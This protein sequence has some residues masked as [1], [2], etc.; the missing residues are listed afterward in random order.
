MFHPEYINPK[1]LINNEDILQLFKIIEKHGGV[2]RFVG[3]AVRDAIAG[4]KRSDI[5]LV[6]DLS[7]SEFSDICVE[8]GLRCVPIGI[9]FFTLDV[10][11]NNSFFKVTCLSTEDDISQEEWK[12][13]AAKRDLTINAVYADD[14]G[15][16]FDYYDGIDDLEKGV[17]K[18]I[19]RP[20]NAIKNDPIRIMRFFR[21]CAMF[22]KKI[23]RKSLKCCIENKHLLHTVSQEKIK[24]ELFKILLAPYAFRAMELVFKYGVLDFLIAPPF[25]VENLEKLD[26]LVQKLDI[27]KGIIRRLF[28]LF[29][30]SP[31][32]AERLAKIFNLNKEQKE[33]FFKLCTAKINAKSFKDSVS[34][35]K[36]IYAYGKNIC[37]DLF[38][39]YSIDNKNIEEIKQTLSVIEKTPV[40]VFP[41]KG[42]D[43]IEIGADK[44]FLSLYMDVL[45]KEWFENGCTYSKE[46]LLEQFKLIFKY[47]V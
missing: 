36:N 9:Q 29:K 19:G 40:P 33:A 37:R 27:E 4:F 2:L 39:C 28:V 45:K 42:K 22:G 1:K 17:I 13:D 31:K 32:R 7:P 14:K 44:K 8:E 12:K 5:D 34:I 15:N 23:D 47:G 30:P 21:F 38:L 46:E 20:I 25:N 24:E 35:N 6:T 11:V 16:V 10:I 43:L 3:G 26:N 41:I 18:F